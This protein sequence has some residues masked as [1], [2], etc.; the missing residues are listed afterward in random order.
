[1]GDGFLMD[2]GLTVVWIGWQHDAP[3]APGTLRLRV[4]RARK[5]DGSPLPDSPDRT[6]H[7][8]PSDRLDLAALGH[9]PHPAAEPDAKENVL[10]VRDS[11]EGPRRIVPREAWHFDE[12]GTQI[13][14]EQGFTPRGKI[15]ELVYVA[16]DPPVVG[17]GLAAFRDIAAYLRHRPREPVPGPPQRR[18]RRLSIRS[19][20]ATIS[21]RGHES[22]RGGPCRLRRRVHPDRRC[23][24][25][26]LQSS[27]LP[28][29]PRGQSLPQLLLSWRRLPLHQRTRRSIR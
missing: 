24:S 4:P 15:Y 19:L 25:R 14:S 1:M 18:R 2:Q 26:R 28:S 6:D 23:R 7:R 21:P 12:T 17:L 29:R 10:S 9:V 3:A 16:H 22:R 20:P 5:K 27:I 8:A 13:V 11:R